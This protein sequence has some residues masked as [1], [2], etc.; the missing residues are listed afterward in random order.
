MLASIAICLLA[1]TFTARDQDVV[2]AYL[3]SI[4]A[5]QRVEPLTQFVVQPTTSS[6]LFELCVKRL[7]ERAKSS[8]ELA[9]IAKCIA[10]RNTAPV[11]LDQLTWDSN[12]VFLDLAKEPEL[13]QSR[14]FRKRF[15]SAAAFRFDL[16]GYSED[17]KSAVIFTWVGPNHIHSVHELA[18]LNLKDGKWKVVWRELAHYL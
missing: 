11:R 17:G 4:V 18:L 16:P 13:I 2:K 6:R 12:I 7:D 8:P 9:P 1:E 3:A 15:P 5:Q 14:N 10:A